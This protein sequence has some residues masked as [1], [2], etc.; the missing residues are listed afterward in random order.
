MPVKLEMSDSWSSF[1]SSELPES[2]SIGFDLSPKKLEHPKDEYNVRFNNYR[3]LN[4]IIFKKI[5]N[6]LLLIILLIFI[7][8]KTT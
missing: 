1:L 8:K 7:L 3:I 4:R 6:I 2:S 5:N